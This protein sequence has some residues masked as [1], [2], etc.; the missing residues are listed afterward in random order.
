METTLRRRRSTN[1]I[2][3]LLTDFGLKDGYA[4]TMKGVIL[5]INP[6]A[7]IGS[8]AFLD[9]SQADNQSPLRTIAN[10]AITASVIRPLIHA[11]LTVYFIYSP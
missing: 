6:E 4:G 11:S 8:V 10:T 2:I 5:A 1:S 7:K 9:V 3:T